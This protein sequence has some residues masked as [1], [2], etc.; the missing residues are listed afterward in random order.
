MLKKLI[1]KD[2]IIFIKYIRKVLWYTITVTGERIIL[3][4]YSKNIW[5]E[6]K[7]YGTV[8]LYRFQKENN[9]DD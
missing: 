6:F 2:L 8:C 7:F 9:R 3:N 1:P 4:M 5:T